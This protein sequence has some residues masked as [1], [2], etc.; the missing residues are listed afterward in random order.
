[1]TRRCSSP[2]TSAC[3][4]FIQDRGCYSA[5]LHS[6]DCFFGRGA[7]GGHAAFVLHDVGQDH[8]CERIFLNNENR[9]TVQ[10]SHREPARVP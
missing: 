1:M 8:R 10:L 4:A 9:T 2:H 3:K 5:L 6:E 7:D